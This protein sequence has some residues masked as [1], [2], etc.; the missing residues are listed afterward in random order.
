MYRLQSAK[1][2]F[3]Q[4][5]LPPRFPHLPRVPYVLDDL[6]T[7]R[8]RWRQEI[9]HD[10]DARSPARSRSGDVQSHPAEDVE[11]HPA[12]QP[13]IE[14]PP[15]LGRCSEDDGPSVSEE[16]KEQSPLEVYEEAILKERQGSLSEA[17]VQYRKAFKVSPHKRH[18]AEWI[19]V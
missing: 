7:F 5:P 4:N 14:E 8:S 9:E 18:V 16:S 11:S 2:T 19:C 1:V 13:F 15:L 6:K 17:V 3:P 10:R 12:A